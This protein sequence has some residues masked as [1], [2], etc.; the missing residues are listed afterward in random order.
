M[1]LDGRDF[2]DLVFNVAGVSTA[3][4]GG[5]GSEFVANGVRSDQTN[6]QV[7]GINNTNPRDS[8]AEA[9]PP[10]DAL[11]EF[12]V[13][14]SNYSAEFGRVA[15][16]VINLSI[17]KGGN[18]LHGSLFEFVRNDLFDAGNYFDVPGTHSELRR[19]QFGGTMGGPIYIPHIYNGHDKTFFLAECGELSAGVGIERHR[20][21]AYAAGARRR[22]FPVLQHLHRG[23]VQY[24]CSANN[25]GRPAHRAAPDLQPEHGIAAS[26]QSQRQEQLLSERLPLAAARRLRSTRSRSS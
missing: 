7:D 22:L 26:A 11:Q 24:A 20:G 15:G 13:Q 12:K 21:C 17:K 8:T 1:P 4:E 6:V 19:N 16:P 2:N 10:L 9:A 5:K 14:T 3:E 23:R 18:V 25:A